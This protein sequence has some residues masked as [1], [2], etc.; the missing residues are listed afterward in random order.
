MTKQFSLLQLF[1][2]ADG[3]LSTSTEDVYNMLQHI[4]DG[5]LMTHHLPV[6]MDYVKNKNPQWL[7]DVKVRLDTIKNTHRAADSFEAII[8]V[9]KEQYNDQYDI[10]QLKDEFDTSDFG[11]FMLDNNLLLKKQSA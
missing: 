4:C 3:R 9:I 2:L 10:P 6:A 1:S 8:D 11:T 7:Q 5:E